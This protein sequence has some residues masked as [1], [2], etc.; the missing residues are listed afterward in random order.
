[1]V[2]GVDGVVSLA[3]R[4]GRGS[5]MRHASAGRRRGA[6][7]EVRRSRP[8]VTN[9]FPSWQALRAK[10][11][12]WMGVVYNQPAV[13]SV[14]VSTSAMGDVALREASLVDTYRNSPP[15]ASVSAR[16]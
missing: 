1:M 3:Q 11:G 8:H 16:E 15:S 10:P 4:G 5:L 12:L 13:H 14:C 7:P 6:L 2:I 9:K